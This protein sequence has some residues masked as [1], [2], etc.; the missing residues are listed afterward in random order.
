MSL[1]VCGLVSKLKIPEFLESLDS[2]DIVAIQESLTD[3]ID[4]INIPGSKLFLNNRQNQLRN[5]SGGIGV[6]IK[7][8]I[9]QYINIDY[10]PSSKLIQWCLISGEITSSTEVKTIPPSNSRYAHDY[11][12]NNNSLLFHLN[13]QMRHQQHG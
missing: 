11:K 12:Y 3:D 1:N 8:S 5:W 2:Y 4:D 6:L 7:D 13:I 9:V 10:L